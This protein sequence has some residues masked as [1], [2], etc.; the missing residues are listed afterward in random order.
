M[1]D[2]DRLKQEC[3]HQWKTCPAHSNSDGSLPPFRI[4]LTCLY[5]GLPTKAGTS[6]DQHDSDE[7]VERIAVA[8]RERGKP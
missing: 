2:P 3:T 7:T 1:S 5:G 6:W 4:V 8:C